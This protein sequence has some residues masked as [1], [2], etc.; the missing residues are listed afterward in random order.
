MDSLNPDTTNES[1]IS[2][3]KLFAELYLGDVGGITMRDTYRQDWLTFSQKSREVERLL[4]TGAEP[5]II[6]YGYRLNDT[7]F[8]AHRLMPAGPGSQFIEE[9]HVRKIIETQNSRL[10]DFM[11]IVWQNMQSIQHE[12]N[13]DAHL[14]DIK[15]PLIDAARYRDLEMVTRLTEF[16]AN[17]T[18][19]AEQI[20]TK[21]WTSLRNP[22]S[23]AVEALDSHDLEQLLKLA[24]PKNSLISRWT[25]QC[26]TRIFEMV[27][28][29]QN[30]PF[31]IG[32]TLL[33]TG[34]DVHSFRLPRQLP[35]SA[36]KFCI[37]N[38]IKYDKYGLTP[39]HIVAGDATAEL[40]RYLVAND[41]NVNA[42]DTFGMSPLL[43][44]VY[45]GHLEVVI[46]LL[47]HG[48]DV[49]HR[50]GNQDT[51]FCDPCGEKESLGNPRHQVVRSFKVK[52]WPALHI[53]AHRGFSS[54][55]NKLIE[56]GANTT[57]L[58][59]SG[60]TA[61]DIAIQGSNYDTAFVLLARGCPLRAD[62]V[63]ASGIMAVAADTCRYCSIRELVKNGVP[64]PAD[65]YLQAKIGINQNW[66]DS[67]SPEAPSF[68]V[69]R[70][71]FH[72]KH[73]RASRSTF[74]CKKCSRGL[75]HV[76]Y[77]LARP[78]KA[79]TSC[80]FCRLLYDCP[81]GSSQTIDVKYIKDTGSPDVTFSTTS[82]DFVRIHNVRRITSKHSSLLY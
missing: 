11:E 71:L 66:H 20:P 82:N 49:N 41:A 34:V 73:N 59:Q 27:G 81:R 45:Y 24:T 21:Y 65:N 55:V 32:A 31:Q 75:H 16:G 43:E 62:S 6:L 37:Q 78:T 36:V 77:V 76:V 38:S 1:S 64:L 17:F 51:E 29:H 47:S 61:L 33:R 25:G 5:N 56:H 42:E 69:S 19:V 52:Q 9:P 10:K 39:L 28:T 72:I 79:K 74:L 4:R 67:I 58:D 18:F 68:K 60:Q 48:A 13:L 23:P 30:E 50:A 54:I 53:A 44:A 14:I 35:K 3:T 22:F 12:P 15:I 40:T 70:S 7:R 46:S 57:F 63:G 8:T 80:N 26:L 2:A